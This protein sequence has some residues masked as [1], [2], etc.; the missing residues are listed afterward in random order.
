MRCVARVD[1]FERLRAEARGTNRSWE[2]DP[3]SDESEDDADLHQVLVLRAEV[4]A[5]AQTLKRLLCS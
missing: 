5:R 4:R 3:F 1:P 2:S